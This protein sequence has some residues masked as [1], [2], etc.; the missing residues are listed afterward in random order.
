MREDDAVE[1]EEG[2]APLDGLFDFRDGTVD[3]VAEMLKDGMGEG[4]GFF[5]VGIDAA[6]RG[7]GAG[8]WWE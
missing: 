7:G 5:D 4:S 8:A 6:V 2:H 1:S 3:E